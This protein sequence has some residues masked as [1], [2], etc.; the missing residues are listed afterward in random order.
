M[1]SHNNKSL[2]VYY[3]IQGNES[4]V[5]AKVFNQNE[6]DNFDVQE[7]ETAIGNKNQ[8]NLTLDRHGNLI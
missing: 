5:F 3:S 4:Q 1:L 7:N 6:N 8:K 2:I